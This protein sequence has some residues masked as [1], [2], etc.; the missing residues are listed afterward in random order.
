MYPMRRC[1]ANACAFIAVIQVAMVPPGCSTQGGSS[2][3]HSLSAGPRAKIDLAGLQPGVILIAPNPKPAD[4]SADP[5]NR[6]VQPISEGAADATRSFMNT[7]SL[8]N[9]QLEA[10]VG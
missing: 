5:A 9:P 8:G 4:I 2:S 7:P 1:V 3:A 10:G 6:R